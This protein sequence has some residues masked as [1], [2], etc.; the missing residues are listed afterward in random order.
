MDILILNNLSNMTINELIIDIIIEVIEEASDYTLECERD[1]LV[2][3]FN[4]EY[5]IFSI[6]DLKNINLC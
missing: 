6:C 2:A 5:D 4:Q 1:R 3:A